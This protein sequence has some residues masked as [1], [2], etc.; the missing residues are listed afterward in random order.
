MDTSKAKIAVRDSFDVVIIGAGVA[1]ALVAHALSQKG[2][3]V[4]ML[5]A[6]E[7]GS[8]RQDLVLRYAAATI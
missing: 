4:L 5:E 6:G 7:T 3:K 1:G 2:V 8:E